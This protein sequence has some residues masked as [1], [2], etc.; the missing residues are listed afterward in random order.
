[1]KDL[2]LLL[3]FLLFSLLFGCNS[4]TSFDEDLGPDAPETM[5]SGQIRSPDAVDVPEIGALD[6]LGIPEIPFLE[7]DSPNPQSSDPNLVGKWRSFSDT[8]NTRLLELYSDGRW[9]LGGSSGTWSVADIEPADWDSWGVPPYGPTRKIIL[10][11]WNQDRADGPIEETEDNVDFFWVI[12]YVTL[13]VY[14]EPA[15]VQ[16]KYGHST[17]E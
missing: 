12:Y 17:W 8:S 11:G 2:H 4:P 15:Q 3:I 5:P 14:G 6:S 1:M 7:D 13:E 10:N 16:V 9:Q